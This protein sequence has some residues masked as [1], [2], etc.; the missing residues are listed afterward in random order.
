M[1]KKTAAGLKIK[2]KE[3]LVA[4]T[5]RIGVQMPMDIIIPGIEKAVQ[6]LSGKS[7]HD[8]ALAIM[9][10]DTKP[11]EAAFSFEIDG[12]TITVAGMVKGAGMIC[13]EVKTVPHATMLAFITTDA[14]VSHKFLTKATS[15]AI[16]L[17]LNRISIDN[18]MST[19]DS[20]FV[21]ANGA[22]ENKRLK[23]SC[24][25]YELFEQALTEVMA[26][27]A[28]QMVLDGEGVTKFVKIDVLNARSVKDARLCARAIA[29]S[30]LCKTAWFGKDPNW[31]RLVAAAGYSGAKFKQEKVNVYYDDKPVVLNGGDAGTKEED[32]AEILKRHDFTITV[33]LNSG[34]KSYY[35]WTG[36]IS[37]DYVKINAD[38]HT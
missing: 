1:T 35:M 31:G 17:S 14:C 20:V 24:K 19:N 9:T 26:S 37:Y 28:K 36:D 22:A 25:Y 34:S 23:G 2:T 12:K 8:A 32:L 29:N 11:K 10:T 13:P 7:G 6:A 4:S 5:G 16:D 3:V 38:Y 21:M 15:N 27:L 30:M 18:D 33:E